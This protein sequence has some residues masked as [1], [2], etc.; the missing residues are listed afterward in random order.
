[1]VVLLMVGSY[2]VGAIPFGLLVGLLRG[3]DIRTVG[4]KNIGATN[5]GRTLGR[6]FGVAAFFLD[7]LKGLCPVLLAGHLL[8]GPDSRGGLSGATGYLCWLVIGACCVAGHNF[9]I[10]LRFRGGKGVATSLGVALG[11]YPEFTYPALVGFAVWVMVVL[12]SRYVSL[13]SIMAGV[14]FPIAYCAI[15]LYSRPGTLGDS[16]PLSG[17]AVLLGVMVL[18]RHRGNL[19]RLLAGTEEKIGQK[20]GSAV[21]PRG[22]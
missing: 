3:V 2:L 16:W 13:A 7:V 5:V 19:G 20:G 6:K 1:M 4:S 18:V 11:V 12:V 8:I 21:T 17:F 9:P 22:S 10:Y 15:S 14:S